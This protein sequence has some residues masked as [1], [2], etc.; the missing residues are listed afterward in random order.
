VKASKLDA[1]SFILP[2]PI[3]AS[4]LNTLYLRFII[5]KSVVSYYISELT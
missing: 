5:K 3:Q 4:Q 1:M 2:N